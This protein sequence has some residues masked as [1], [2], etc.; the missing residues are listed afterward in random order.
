M[1]T[2]LTGMGA[3][4]RSV[5]NIHNDVADGWIKK[6]YSCLVN[7]KPFTVRVVFASN[8]EDWVDQMSEAPGLWTIGWPVE[9]GYTTGGSIDFVAAIVDKTFGSPDI[10]GRVEGDLTLDPSGKPEI[11]A[12]TPVED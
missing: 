5:P 4:R 6:L 7:P 3:S 10:E 9:E 1:I 11:T 8:D 2:G 12:G